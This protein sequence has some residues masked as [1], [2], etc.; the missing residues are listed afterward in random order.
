MDAPIQNSTARV[1]AIRAYLRRHW[2]RALQ[3]REKVRL[4]EEAYHLLL[5]G[6]VGIIGGLANLV[7]N[8]SIF[9]LQNLFFSGFQEKSFFEVGD[10][11]TLLNR[12]AIPTIGALAAGL[13]LFWGI[14]LVGRQSTSNLLEV[15][16]AGDGRLPFRTG[17]IRTLASMTS[18]ATG[19]SLGREG[20]ITQISATLASKWG[21]LAHWHPY[22]LRLLVACGAASGMAAAYNAPIAGAVFAA[23]IV[24]GNFSMN[25]FAPILFSSVVASMLARGLSAGHPWYVVPAFN[26]TSLGQLPWFILLGALSGLLGA[27]FLKL[28]AHTEELFKKIPTLYLRLA[29]GGFLA[30]IIALV[31]PE[32]RGNGYQG[33]NEILQGHYEIKL[34]VAVLIAKLLATTLTVGSGAVGGVFTPTLFLGVALGTFWGTIL[35]HLDLAPRNLPVGVFALVGMGSMLSATT[36]SPLLAIIM[37]F[38]ISLNYSLMPALMLGCAVST[39]VSRAFHPNSIYTEPL[40]IRSLEVESYRLGTATEQTV[41]DLMHAPIEPLQDTTPL[42]EIAERFLASTNNNLPVVNKSQQLVGLVALQDLKEYLNDGSELM[43]VIASDVMRTVPICVTPSQRLLDLLPEIL[44]SEQRNIPVINNTSEHKLIGSLPR[45]EVVGIFTETLS[46][47]PPTG[48]PV[49]PAPPPA[50]R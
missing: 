15:V 3:I 12:L 37:I 33:A 48:K 20:A 5:A 38:E 49:H 46:A 4:S 44:A 21:Q 2:Q 40:K 32:V 50:P 7:F 8:E 23:Q 6:G 26:F 35:Q 27:L 25:L 28:L 24:L 16:V 22:R 42:P 34:L 17:F 31:F 11:A 29:C 14:R 47:D 13:I 30:A 9:R 18:I 39:L 19:A 41:G 36:H 45:A 43:P 10:F 1:R